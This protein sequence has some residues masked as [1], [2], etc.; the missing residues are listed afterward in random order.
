[1][2]AEQARHA[3]NGTDARGLNS[4]TLSGSAAEM[5]ERNMVPAIFEPFANDLLEFANLKKGEGVLDVACGTGIVA[6]LAWPN[7]APTGRVVGLDA[8]AGML[9]VAQLLA[10]QRGLD[11]NWAEGNVSAL[12]FDSGEFD[13]VLCQ[14]G[15]QYFPDRPAALS[16]I[17]RVLD[18]RGRL[19][20]NVWRPIRFNAG[21]SVFADVLQRRV[22]NEAAET[23]RAP[24]KLSDQNEI[25]TLVADAGFHDVV[26]SLTTRIA[27][28]ASAEAMVRIMIA[29]TPLGATMNNNDSEVLQSVIGEVTAG[30]VEYVDDR[31]LAIPMQGWVV[32][33]RA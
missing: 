25:R 8:N 11:I 5:Y 21:H 26:T 15:L 1:M 23:R 28:F 16:E 17:H 9:E 30:L 33:A 31:G 3:D 32:T 4:Y 19:V 7:V 20:L 14:H 29:G 24:F 22:S 27:R 13:V 2:S 18:R 6:R 10:R 12:P